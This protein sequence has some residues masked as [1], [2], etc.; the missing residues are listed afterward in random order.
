M[1][2]AGGAADAGDRPLLLPLDLLPRTERRSVRD[3]DAR[4]GFTADEALE[5]LGERLSLPPKF[6][7]LRDQLEPVLTPLPNPRSERVRR[8]SRR[9]SGRPAGQADG[10]LVLF[11]GRGADEYDLFG[12]LD[13]LDP[14]RRLRGLL[15]ARRRSRCRRAAPLVRRAARRLPRAAVVRPGLRGSRRDSLDALP[16]ARERMVLGG[17]SQGAVMRFRGRAR[18]AAVRARRRSSRSRAW[19]RL[20]RFVAGTARSAG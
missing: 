7:H 15:P 4:A 19:S 5:Q 20:L 14:E 8:V 18:G 3:R 17:F 2:A 11:H 10:A 9:R 13:A 1:I 16:G 12:L 6:E